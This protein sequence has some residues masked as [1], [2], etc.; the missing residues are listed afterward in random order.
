MTRR[1][2]TPPPPPSTKRP[3][4]ATTPPYTPGGVTAPEKDDAVSPAEKTAPPNS[5]PPKRKP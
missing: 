5:Y 3:P 4:D 1:L 2:D